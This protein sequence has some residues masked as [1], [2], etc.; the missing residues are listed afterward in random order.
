MKAVIGKYALCAVLNAVL[1]G[2][3]GTAFAG[4]HTWVVNEV[5]SN[6][7]G[8][9]QF[10]EL[11]ESGGGAG[12]TGLPGL[13]VSSSLHSTGLGGGS[14]TP[15]T[16]NKFFLIATPDFAA[17]PGAPAPNITLPAGSV[18]FFSKT[19][20]TVSY[21]PYDSFAF[22]VVP[23]N[24]VNSLN[25]VGGVLPNSPTNYAGVS[26]SVVAPS[27]APSL[28]EWGMGLAVAMLLL[29]GTAVVLRSRATAT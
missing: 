20:D 14:L 13:T 29:A 17:L 5:F 22:G 2:A 28:N 6:K 16:S 12:E 18:P 11:R 10:V 9:I 3:A 25:R 4:A 21:N 19:G 27:P 15:P 24:G 26:G 7:S 1:V 23:T 8:T